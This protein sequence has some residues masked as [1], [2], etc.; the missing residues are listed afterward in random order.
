MAKL[1][2]AA[3]YI[4]AAILRIHTFEVRARREALGIP[5]WFV[6]HPQLLEMPSRPTTVVVGSGRWL[7][8]SDSMADALGN[9][10]GQSVTL[11]KR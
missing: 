1:G 2:T 8:V 4:I 11:L 5:R 7:A 6:R 3:D 10:T 9:P